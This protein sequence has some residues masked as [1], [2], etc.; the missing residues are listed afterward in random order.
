MDLPAEPNSSMRTHRFITRGVVLYPWDLL[1][2]ISRGARDHRRQ[3]GRVCAGSE[4]DHRKL[5]LLAR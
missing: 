3:G 5:L 1:S 2:L 4:A